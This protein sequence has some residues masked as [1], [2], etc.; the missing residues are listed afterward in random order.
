MR[1]TNIIVLSLMSL[2]AC[3]AQDLQGTSSA[4]N[5]NSAVSAKSA[6][7]PCSTT[8]LPFGGGNGTA[9]SPNLI[10]TAAQF[11][12][13]SQA[14]YNGQ[15]AQLW[16]DIGI[17]AITNMG[18]FSGTLDGNGYLLG[19][20]STTTPGSA[21]GCGLFASV[22]GTIKNLTLDYMTINCSSYAG[23]AL[24]AVLTSTGV[25]ANVSV[26]DSHI[27]GNSAVGGVIGSV[28]GTA[29]QIFSWS[30]VITSPFGLGGLV[31]QITLGGVVTGNS[32]SGSY[33]SPNQSGF[34]VG[35]LHGTITCIAKAGMSFAV[36]NTIGYNS[37]TQ[38]GCP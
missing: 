16:A 24:A 21:A 32:A 15:Y 13:L 6:V 31:G 23:G 9:S 18:D 33:S 27:T 12:N 34:V 5:A 8:T 30:N 38:N 26:H 14:P 20:F 19:G 28:A 35:I 4:L 11:Q 36:T 3:T 7:N 29:T 25:V 2:T 1:Y 22:S 10:C 17:Q 37:G